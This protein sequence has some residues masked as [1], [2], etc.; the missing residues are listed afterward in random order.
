MAIHRFRQKHCWRFRKMCIFFGQQL[1]TQE[2]RCV[3]RQDR[4]FSFW[5]KKKCFFCLRVQLL[6]ILCNF[7]WRIYTRNKKCGL[8]GARKSNRIKNKTWFG[9]RAAAIDR[10]REKKIGAAVGMQGNASRWKTQISRKMHE[11]ASSKNTPNVHDVS[12]THQNPAEPIQF[13]EWNRSP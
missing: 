7:E 4:W 6:C 13:S 8:G 12:R 5:D 2:R 3:T 1:V 9:G 10:C 11:N